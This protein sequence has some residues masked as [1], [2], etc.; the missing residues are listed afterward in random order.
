MLRIRF[1]HIAIVAAGLLLAATILLVLRDFSRDRSVYAPDFTEAAFQRIKV[2][3]T[4]RSVYSL[5][6]SPL[7]RTE[8]DSQEAWCYADSQITAG[9]TTTVLD[10]T[11]E[12]DCVEF[13][14]KGNVA[15][16][17]GEE[18]RRRIEPGARRE[19]VL[20]LL[21]EPKEIYPQT[22]SILHYSA[23]S[24]SGVYRARIISLDCA[25]LVSDITTYSMHD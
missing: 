17:T 9:W 20:E 3:M 12:P 13:D 21:G 4:E 16:V 24:D 19:V 7:I 8:V 2:G 6:G 23:P 22:S 1:L 10:L 18:P 14:R 5:L 25:G 11:T 15:A